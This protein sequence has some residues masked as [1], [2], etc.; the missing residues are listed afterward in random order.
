MTF[1][2]ARLVHHLPLQPRASHPLLGQVPNISYETLSPISHYLLP[3]NY[4]LTPF[5]ELLNLQHINRHYVIQNG[6][7]Q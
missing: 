3:I 5:L 7:K 2:V 6:L 1:I 4:L